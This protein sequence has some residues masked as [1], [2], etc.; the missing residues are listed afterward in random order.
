MVI[1]IKALEFQ[2]FYPG[3]ALQPHSVSGDLL[4]A[5]TTSNRSISRFCRMI[6]GRF[7]AAERFNSW[8]PSDD[9]DQLPDVSLT[10][11][12]VNGPFP[13]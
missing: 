1:Y 5:W 6:I 7:P 8:P 4:Y 13:T 12:G 2:L 11:S 10:F 9:S 3:I